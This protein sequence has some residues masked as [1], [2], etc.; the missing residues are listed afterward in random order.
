MVSE[1]IVNS[2]KTA[3]KELDFSVEK[4]SLEHPADLLHGDYST[5]IALVLAKKLKE[6]PRDVAEKIVKFMQGST[7]QSEKGRTFIER[8]EVAGAGFIN[9]YLS[10]KYFSESLK[11]ILE[12]DSIFGKGKKNDEKKNKL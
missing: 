1:V 8:I 7:L 2:L 6:K 11:E 3:L 4:I 5:N 12:K 9:F 10:P